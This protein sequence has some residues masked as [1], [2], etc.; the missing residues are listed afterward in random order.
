MRGQK[1][2]QHDADVC[3][4]MIEDINSV[5][6]KYAQNF[7]PELTEELDRLGSIMAAP[8]LVSAWSLAARGKIRSGKGAPDPEK[9]AEAARYYADN[10]KIQMEPQRFTLNQKTGEW[11]EFQPA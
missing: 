7:S 11:K 1:I 9:F 3:D 4:A 5:V 2:S 6:K 10:V 8:L